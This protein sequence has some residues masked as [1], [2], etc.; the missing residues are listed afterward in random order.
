MKFYIAAR[1]SRRPECNE[2]AHRL[3]A[4]GHEVTSRWVKPETDHVM[5]TGLSAQAADSERKRF[6]MEDADDVHAAD[7]M[8]S[9]M[10]EPRSNS[11]GGRHVEFGM[12]LALG[13]S[14]Y[15]IGPRETVFHHYPGV[16]QFETA[17]QF[18]DHISR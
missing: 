10:E 1:F 7:A 4:L 14:L 11:R 15:I 6:A 9:F 18:L 3:L 17:D 5:P 16:S 12:A 8:V 13:H 2:L